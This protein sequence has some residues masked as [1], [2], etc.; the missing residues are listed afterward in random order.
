VI[1]KGTVLDSNYG[2]DEGFQLLCENSAFGTRHQL[3]KANASTRMT[4]L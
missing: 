3:F 1:C 2:L 4:V